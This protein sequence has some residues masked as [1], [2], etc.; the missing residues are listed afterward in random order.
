MS[1]RLLSFDGFLPLTFFNL[2]IH[3][4]DFVIDQY[5]SLYTQQ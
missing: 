1:L 4:E 3:F 2:L 5:H